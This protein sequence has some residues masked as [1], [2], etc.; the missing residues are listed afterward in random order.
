MNWVGPF[1]LVICLTP[2][3]TSAQSNYHLDSLKNILAQKQASGD[4]LGETETLYAIGNY[5][6]GK[7]EDS[8]AL[9]YNQQALQK[10]PEGHPALKGRILYRK[11][12]LH[13][14]MG[15]DKSEYLTLF[16]SAYVLLKATN[17]IKLL[18]VFLQSYGSVLLQVN[19]NQRSM[20]MMIE[21][22]RLLL[23]YPAIGTPDNLLN[24]YSN[25]VSSGLQLGDYEACL[26]YARK[27]IE[28]GKKSNNFELLADLHYN[29]ALILLKLGYLKEA[30]RGYL[31]SLELNK[32][33]KISSGIITVTTALGQYYGS[34]GKPELGLR[35][36]SQAKAEA[37]KKQDFYSVAM[38][39]RSESA[40]LFTQKEYHRALA[41]IDSCLQYFEK[42]KNINYQP[43]NFHQKA[44]V[45]NELGQIES[46]IEW[47]KKEIERAPQA[48]N[49]P[50]VQEVYQ[51]LFDIEKK[52]GNF[53]EALAYY[54][55]Y[56]LFKDSFYNEGLKSKLAEERT[57]QNIE[58]EQDARQKAELE[59]ELLT[60]R[61]QLLATVAIV[62]LLLLVISG[63]LYLELRKSRR[64]LGEQN[65]DLARLNETK[66]KFFGIIAHDL[67]NPISAFNGVGD[68][69]DHYLQMG[70]TAKIQRLIQLVSKSAANLSSLLD[71]LLS[72]AL[73]NRG[74]IPYNP[75][76]LSLLT[77]S[78]TC[79][80]IH[81]YSASRKGI[82][83]ENH[84]AQNVKV[85]ADCNALQT[86]LRNL[87]D[88]AI[89][90][91][92]AAGVVSL[93]CEEKAE[94]VVISIH[95]SG[96]GMSVEKLDKLFALVKRS[97]HG[98]DGEKGAGLGLLISKELVEINHGAIRVFS[99]EGKGSTFEFS[100]PKAS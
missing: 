11:A 15:K 12:I 61:N 36:L 90:F 96:K 39:N 60:S 7:Q 54:E 2:F 47:A 18:G 71:N 19:Q 86:I 56:T 16:D 74:M 73:L 77:E 13:F 37:I 29:N 41:A 46:A 22:E 76:P 24:L 66:D 75:E 78:T 30:K 45:L 95:D 85:F 43:G 91:T 50:V 35:Y 28:V 14:F 63:Y 25:M 98:T 6:Y 65:R 8:I 23:Q 67:R 55:K 72:W 93:E 52:R 68:Q 21:A 1:F 100:L 83:L 80:Q 57:K 44:L 9:E 64:L 31:K 20:D 40:I 3:L 10:L 81:E 51:F 79:F 34:N 17:E 27:G 58:A 99:T 82:R 32:K 70:D 33:G 59:S 69:F 87:I 42:N 48:Y 5:Y 92:P 4:Q 53:E 88:N 89:K 62:L 84:I 97:E 49:H 26:N 94:R 38:A